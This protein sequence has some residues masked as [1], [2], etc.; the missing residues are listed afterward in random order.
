MDLFTRNKINKCLKKSKNFRPLI[1][2]LKIR[3]LNKLESSRLKNQTCRN[4]KRLP[5]TIRK[6]KKIWMVNCNLSKMIS[7]IPRIDSRKLEKKR[8]T[9]RR[10]QKTTKV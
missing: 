2:E 7:K 8:K 1:E 4:H 6:I 10:I 9:W 5:R 3:R